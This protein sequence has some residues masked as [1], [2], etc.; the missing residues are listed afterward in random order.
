MRIGTGSCRTGMG[1]T[2]RGELQP[3]ASHQ[4]PLTARGL[5]LLPELIR[6]ADERNVLRGLRV[7]M[8][9][10]PRFAAMAAL[11]VNVVKLFEDEGFQTALGGEGADSAEFVRPHRR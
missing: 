5:Q 7:G 3:T 9:D 8:A 11:I 2:G 4:N 1:K 6:A 10:D